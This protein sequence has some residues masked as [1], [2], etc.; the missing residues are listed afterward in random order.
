MHT[1]K[2]GGTRRTGPGRLKP[3]GGR[4][5]Y[6]RPMPRCIGPTS[7]RCVSLFG[8][9][10]C[11]AIPRSQEKAPPPWDH[12]MTLSTYYCRGLRG[13]GSYKR[14]AP[15]SCFRALG[16]AGLLPRLI[17]SRQGGFCSGAVFALKDFDRSFQEITATRIA[18][19]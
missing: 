10:P 14:G 16:A 13:G 9:H 19:L 4:G 2:R 18:L 15:V 5:S 3:H 1:R 6:R 11:A 8:G 12:H 17:C 7:R